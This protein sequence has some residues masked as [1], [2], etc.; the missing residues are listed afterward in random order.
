V[1][2]GVVSCRRPVLFEIEVD[3]EVVFEFAEEVD[4]T[5]VGESF[6]L[7]RSRTR[8]PEGL[9]GV[10]SAESCG[11]LEEVPKPK[12]LSSRRRRTAYRARQ[13]GN[14]SELSQVSMTR[15]LTGSKK[16][17]RSLLNEVCR[18]KSEV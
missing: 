4:E 2:S 18:C 6:S 7:L 8:D 5:G 13:I 3:P 10:G 14:L 16:R 11:R 9:T 17:Q 12:N 15:E 1:D